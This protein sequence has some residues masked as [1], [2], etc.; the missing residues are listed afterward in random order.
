MFHFL[1]LLSY[2]I[3]I[4]LKFSESLAYWTARRGPIRQCI[5][6]R[7]IGIL[8]EVYAACSKDWKQ[9][10]QQPISIDHSPM[11]WKPYG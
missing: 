2:S 11:L 3:F 6:F 10:S 7:V 5:R 9:P 1:H 4:L 8:P